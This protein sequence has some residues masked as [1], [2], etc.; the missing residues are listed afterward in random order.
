VFNRKAMIYE[1]QAASWYGMFV[2]SDGKNPDA[3][4]QAIRAWQRYRQH[5]STRDANLAARADDQ[6]A[7]LTDIGQRVQ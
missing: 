2:T 7:R 4:D 1:Q 6:I 5:V 3:L